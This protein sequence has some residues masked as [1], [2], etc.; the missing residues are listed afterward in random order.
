MQ[1]TRHAVW[2]DP[3]WGVRHSHTDME[4]TNPQCECTRHLSKMTFPH[5]D[6]IEGYRYDQY[7]DSQK[8]DK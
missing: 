6:F 4:C 5:S 3:K 8:D 7:A 2:D 1:V